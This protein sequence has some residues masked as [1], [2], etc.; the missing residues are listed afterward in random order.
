MH[1]TLAFS[2]SVQRTTQHVVHAMRRVNRFEFMTQ[3]FLGSFEPD[4]RHPVG[5]A[6]FID[7]GL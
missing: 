7:F 5:S 2:E 1:T 6:C 4:E 3:K